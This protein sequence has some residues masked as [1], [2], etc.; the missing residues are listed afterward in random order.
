MLDEDALRKPVVATVEFVVILVGASAIRLPVTLT[1]ALVVMVDADSTLT[2]AGAF[3]AALTVS[4][5]VLRLP[6]E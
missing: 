1:G 3:I 2:D 4:A 6:N 5:P